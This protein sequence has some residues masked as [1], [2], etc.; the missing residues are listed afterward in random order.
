MITIAQISSYN[1]IAFIPTRYRDV[2]KIDVP[3]TATAGTSWQITRVSRHPYY[4]SSLPEPS[5]KSTINDATLVINPSRSSAE[6]DSDIYAV[7]VDRVVSVTP[8]S[9]DCT[10]R[11]D[12]IALRTML[13]RETGS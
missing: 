3:G 2:L 8:L 11:T 9:L 5:L 4:M 12:F 6:L 7:T 13:E 10:S 1:F